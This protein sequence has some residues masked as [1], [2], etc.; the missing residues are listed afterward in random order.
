[1]GR[2]G[3]GNATTQKTRKAWA[4][5][6][7]EHSN[8]AGKPQPPPNLPRLHLGVAACELGGGGVALIYYL[9]ITHI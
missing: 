1:M 8:G 6:R 9:Y 3:G 5:Y 2:S 4:R 7:P